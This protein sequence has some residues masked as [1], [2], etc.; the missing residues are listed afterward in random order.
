MII[1]WSRMLHRIDLRGRP[2]G[3]AVK[4]THSAL[5]ARGSLF[6]IP[7]VDMTP[8]G[9]PCCDRHHTYKVKEDGHGC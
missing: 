8:L 9:K 7:D 6:W 2:G 5:A 3:A 1:Y 4:F